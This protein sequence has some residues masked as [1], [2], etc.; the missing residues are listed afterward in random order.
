VVPTFTWKGRRLLYSRLQRLLRWEFWPAPIF[1]LPVV[2]YVA[3]LCVRFRSFTLF[4]AANPFMELGGFIGESKSRV[5]DAVSASDSTVVPPY[6]FLDES[7]TANQKRDLAL[8]FVSGVGGGYPVVLKPDVGER[9][10]GVVILRSQEELLDRVRLAEAPVILQSYCEGLEFGVFYY[11]YPSSDKGTVF[12]ITEK[13][14]PTVDGDGV[15]TLEDLILKDP[16]AVLSGR[17]F[18]RQ[19]ASGLTSVPPAGERVVLA[20]LGTHA[21]GALFLDGGRHL[22]AELS[23]RIDRI[24]RGIDGFTFGRFDIL[25]PSVEDFHSGENL[26]VIELNGATSEATH[27]Y[28]PGYPLLNA[29][30]TLFQQWR[31]LF[32]IWAEKK[33]AGVKPDGIWAVGKALFRRLEEPAATG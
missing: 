6:L 27:I 18:L 11:R 4:T 28:E 32:E 5:L 20:K 16:R 30:R 15:S 31:I 22:T 33:A 10:R 8:S 14:F 26:Q 12:S 3:A 13:R 2:L 9:G 17:L 21:R 24:S 7:K 29:Y 1:Y 23:D 19:H 25:V